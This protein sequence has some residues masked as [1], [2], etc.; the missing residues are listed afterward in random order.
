MKIALAQLNYHIGNFQANLKRILDAA[1][2]AE[3]EGADL[4]L[5]SELAICGYPP[6]DLLERKDFVLA[7]QHHIEDLATRLPR[8]LGI[9]VGSPEFNPNPEGKLLYNAVFFSSPGKSRTGIPQS[10]SS[11]L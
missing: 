1:N 6:L 11:H 9:L 3:G 10:T 2:R 4:V 7:C 5:F 8:E